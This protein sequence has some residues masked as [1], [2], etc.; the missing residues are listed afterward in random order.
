M[1][2][3]LGNSSSRREYYKKNKEIIKN[4]SKLYRQ[5]NKDYL[6]NYFKTYFK[7]R[8]KIDTRF[9]MRV[10]L[11]NRVH[12]AFKNF[13]TYGKIRSSDSYGIDYEP[14]VNKLILE[15]PKDFKQKLYHIDHKEALCSFDLNKQE[16]V[17]KAFARAKYKTFLILSN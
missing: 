4:K 6:R 1:K 7:N 3:I 8:K 11:R 15:L 12:R 5:L 9:W 10:N 17:K 16:D 2:N 14:I 13:S